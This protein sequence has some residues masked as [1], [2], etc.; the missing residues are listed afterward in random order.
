MLH[1]TPCFSSQQH[2]DRTVSVLS[3]VIPRLNMLLQ[4][5]LIDLVPVQD[6]L[7]GILKPL[8][9]ARLAKTSRGFRIAVKAYLRAQYN[10]HALLSRFF[11]DIIAFRSLQAQTGT[12]ISG[13]VALNFFQR[14]PCA[15]D[16]LD[17]FVYFHH[18][19]RVARWLVDAG[20][21]FVP[22]VDQSP[23]FDYTI[24]E[25]VFLEGQQSTHPS[26][27]V[28]GALTFQRSSRDLQ[29]TVRMYVAYQTPVEA[30]LRASCSA[31]IVL[32]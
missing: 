24:T 7:F 32:F 19:T 5:S 18:R 6:A 4:T 31:F 21:S 14:T 12:L 2:A 22:H 28:C 16:P 26:P 11:I 3:S 17:I 13:F 1:C 15:S 8:T 30:I 10:P 23:D 9:L 27:G 25:G 20:Y 29:T